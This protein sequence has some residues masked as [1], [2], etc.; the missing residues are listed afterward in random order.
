MNE[1]GLLWLCYPKGTAKIKTDLNRDVLR[2]TV[3]ARHGL[4]GV[5]L[6]AIDDTWSAMRFR[7]RS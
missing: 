2:E 3:A 4:E 1:G 5:S 7:S 6:V